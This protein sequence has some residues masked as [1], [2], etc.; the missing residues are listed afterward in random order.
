M[1]IKVRDEV[2]TRNMMLSVLVMMLTWI[3]M[4]ISLAGL[5]DLPRCQYGDPKCYFFVKVCDNK[6]FD[7]RSLKGADS[8]AFSNDGEKG[9]T[10]QRVGVNGTSY[11]VVL[12]SS[13][14]YMAKKRKTESSSDY[15]IEQVSV[16]ILAS[17][18]G[19][20]PGV[21]LTLA[22]VI[23]NERLLFSML[24]IGKMFIAFNIVLLVVSC[25][26]IDALTWDCRWWGEE[27]HPD[28]DKCQGA[29][30]K[31]VVGTTFIFITEFLLLCG[32]I[33]Y[34]E[35]ERKRVNDGRA[36]FS[37]GPDNA[38]DSVTMNTRTGQNMAAPPP[39]GPP[40]Q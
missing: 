21:S 40:G 7:Q 12:P 14:V 17:V 10:E 23:R 38:T 34:T 9:Q 29:Y 26:Q 15:G 4:A 18:L 35:M 24:E 3:G 28:S 16:P 27:Y 30:D 22:M 11:K 36:W 32:G 33:A 13:C 1:A 5:T 39:M 31:Y 19:V 6:L 8:G 2:C 25:M 37:D 20:V